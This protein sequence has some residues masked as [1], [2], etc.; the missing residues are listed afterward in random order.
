MDRRIRIASGTGDDGAKDSMKSGPSCGQA[1][2]KGH[3]AFN[4]RSAVRSIIIISSKWP[5][6]SLRLSS[7]SRNVDSVPGAFDASS[8]PS[9][10]H[11]GY[12]LSEYS[13]VGSSQMIRYNRCVHG[14]QK[15][16]LWLYYGGRPSV[17]MEAPETV[18]WIFN[19]A[20][21]GQSVPTFL[22][23]RDCDWSD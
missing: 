1:T 4:T 15:G 2:I 8:S 22:F 17:S 20:V 14:L 21:Q 10:M 18:R 16:R 12:T 3:S 19:S 23:A 7:H 11:R 13:D 9:S 5:C 6:S